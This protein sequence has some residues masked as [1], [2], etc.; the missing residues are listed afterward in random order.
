MKK[1]MKAI[2]GSPWM[3]YFGGLALFCGGFGLMLTSAFDIGN[4]AG[5]ASCI[6]YKY[7]ISE[8]DR[9]KTEKAQET[10]PTE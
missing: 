9:I 8:V 6:K 4:E 7:V 2:V 1:T 5:R 10:E 3:R